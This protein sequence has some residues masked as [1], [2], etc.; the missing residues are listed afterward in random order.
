[1]LRRVGLADLRFRA[2]MIDD[3]II[4]IADLLV[5]IFHPK[6]SLVYNVR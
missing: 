6:T 5:S 4:T 1:M 3:L 2:T